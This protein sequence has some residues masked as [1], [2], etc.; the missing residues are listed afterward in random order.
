MRVELVGPVLQLVV[1]EAGVAGELAR[2]AAGTKPASSASERA[3]PKMNPR[4]SGATTCD[5]LPPAA[6][7][8]AVASSCSSSENASGFA[9]SGVASL[10]LMPGRGK[11][12]T[13]RISDRRS[14]GA[15]RG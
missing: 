4:A 9:I 6:S 15:S 3:P 7:R 14:T 12:G 10:K 8:V 2:L 11:S 5:T 13:S 1:R